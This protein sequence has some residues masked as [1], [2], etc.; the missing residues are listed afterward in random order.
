VTFFARELA[1]VEGLTSSATSGGIWGSE[2]DRLGKFIEKI[3]R[4]EPASF[5]EVTR[6]IVCAFV[7]HSGIHHALSSHLPHGGK[8]ERLAQAPTAVVWVCADRF[9]KTRAI[10][11]IVPGHRER[12][13]STI[14]GLS[15]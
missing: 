2:Q 1:Q 11:L 5:I 12:R 14:A 3:P 13:E 10:Q 7:N 4:R 8:D 15:D 9:E 6:C